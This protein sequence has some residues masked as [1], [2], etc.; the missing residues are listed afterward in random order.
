ML[1][2]FEIPLSGY[3][4]YTNMLGHFDQTWAIDF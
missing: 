2:I 1:S 3:V 4:L